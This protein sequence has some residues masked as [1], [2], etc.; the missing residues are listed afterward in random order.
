[1]SKMAIPVITNNL[2]VSERSQEGEA[3]FLLNWKGLLPRERHC[4]L[5][6]M[7][8]GKKSQAGGGSAERISHTASK[9][10]NS[11]EPGL[12][13]TDKSACWSPSPILQGHDRELGAC[14]DC[15]KKKGHVPKGPVQK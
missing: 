3:D 6:L 7:V 9:V 10:R 12:G 14:P 5:A 13:A 1:M 8:L 11:K 2:G 15:R 4:C